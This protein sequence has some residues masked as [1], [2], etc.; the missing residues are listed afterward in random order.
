MC[1]IVSVLTHSDLFLLAKQFLAVFMRCGGSD[2]KYRARF[3]V[4]NGLVVL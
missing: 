4:V 1:I 2:I 3:S